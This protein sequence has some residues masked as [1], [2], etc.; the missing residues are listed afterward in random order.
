MRRSNVLLPARL[1]IRPRRRRINLG[2][3]GAWLTRRRIRIPVKIMRLRRLHHHR[4]QRSHRPLK[5]RLERRVVR[6]HLR[7]CGS[8]ALR[9]TRLLDLLRRCCRGS[10]A[11][12][13]QQRLRDVR[14]AIDLRRPDARPDARRPRRRARVHM[15]RV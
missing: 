12:I 10:Q 1:R 2:L 9:E 6:Q 14:T 8:L 13:H 3:R 4:I 5:H 7:A 11:R 15:R